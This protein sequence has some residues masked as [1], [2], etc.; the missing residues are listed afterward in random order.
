MQGWDPSLPR[1][2]PLL[3]HSLGPLL[4]PPCP[5]RSWLASCCLQPLEPGEWHGLN[6]ILRMDFENFIYDLRQIKCVGFF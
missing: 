1:H 3:V 4:H 2:S 6:L 5:G